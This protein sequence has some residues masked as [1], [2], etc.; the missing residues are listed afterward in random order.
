MLQDRLT[1]LKAV[2]PLT[3]S[4]DDW[5]T[6]VNTWPGDTP[7]EGKAFWS[8]LSPTQKRTD[9][10]PTLHY[11]KDFIQNPGRQRVYEAME[12]KFGAGLWEDPGVDALETTYRAYKGLPGMMKEG[13]SSA[14]GDALASQMS[15]LIFFMN[16]TSEAYRT[17][18]CQAGTW[19]PRL[20][21]WLGRLEEND[22][23]RDHVV[24]KLLT[25]GWVDHWAETDQG[26][27]A[28]QLRQPHDVAAWVTGG[29]NLD[30][31][32]LDPTQP[33][34]PLWALLHTRHPGLKD[35]LVGLSR[36]AHQAL[37]HL[38][39]TDQ[40]DRML[41]T[42]RKLDQNHS[43]RLS[44]DVWWT[45]LTQDPQWMQLR[46][47]QNDTP[48]W[49]ALLDKNQALLPL[50]VKEAESNPDFQRHIQDTTRQGEGIWDVLMRHAGDR[51]INEAVVTRLAR[52]VPPTSPT[53][54]LSTP[55]SGTTLPLTHNAAATD[56]SWLGRRYVESELRHVIPVRTVLGTPEQQR[57]WV[58]LALENHQVNA[59]ETLRSLTEKE[60]RPHQA[61]LLPE[62]TL[63]AAVLA[64]TTT[65]TT[66]GSGWDTTGATLRQRLQDNPVLPSGLEDHLDRWKTRLKSGLSRAADQEF[67]DIKNILV[68]VRRLQDAQAPESTPVRSRHRYRS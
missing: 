66:Q 9:V 50:L 45:T 12:A 22:P 52:L 55:P 57:E 49:L 34:Q 17:R 14:Y 35:Q 64:W 2:A 4:M 18:H 65:L 31:L 61:E 33:D 46:V 47:A 67:L 26:P 51:S 20:A 30:R 24:G 29:G 39:T 8:F 63:V 5:E 62:V 68:A 11:A 48:V 58:A 21:H 32:G 23:V 36:S 42:L 38:P 16:V 25:H 44:R 1:I 6:L 54:R 28:L 60:W 41:D 3:G 53:L 56:K 27:L 40:A 37:G 10:S 43:G 7:E 59:L 13:S 15:V 19:V